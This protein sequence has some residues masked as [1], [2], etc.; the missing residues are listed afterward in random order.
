RVEGED[1]LS[2]KNLPR[3]YRLRLM[4]E[5]REAPMLALVA[6][7][8]LVLGRSPL[9]ADYIAQFRPRG[10]VNDARTRRIG[11]AQTYLQ[12]RMDRLRID[13]PD[14]L[15]PSVVLETPMR[16]RAAVSLPTEVVIAGEYGVKIL[17]T[18]SVCAKG[19]RLEGWDGA[20]VSLMQGA[21]VVLPESPAISLPCQA[22][23]VVSDVTLTLDSQGRP[24][25]KTDGNATT[26][27]GRIHRFGG[28]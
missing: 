3:R 19:R 25:V 21:M 4:P 17:L 24:R 14:A 16:Q 6:D 11:R 20:D 27:A 22:A 8:P 1:A 9:E 26:A 13:E 10:N 5:S 12:L 2:A 7:S 23:L 18:S 15:N 28:Q